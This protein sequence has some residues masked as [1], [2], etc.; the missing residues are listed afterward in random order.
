MSEATPE[1]QPKRKRRWLRYSLRSFLVL[2]TIACLALGYWV[3]RANRQRA[4]MKWVL[5]NGGLAWH[6]YRFDEEGAFIETSSPVPVYLEPLLDEHYL[7]PVTVVWCEVPSADG[8]AEIG[9]LANFDQLE[10]LRL[11]FM[12]TRDLTPLANL[13]ELR[14]LELE[15]TKVRDLTPLA[16]LKN[17][18]YLDLD[19]TAISNIEPLRGLSNLESLELGDTPVS[20]LS[21]LRELRNLKSLSIYG[22]RVT[23]LVPLEGLTSLGELRVEK[24]AFSQPQLN[25]LQQALP[26]CKIVAN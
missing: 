19:G 16:E 3:H 6:E 15:D 26:N 24:S 25:K 13:T 12:E 11:N 5:E 23:D 4:A 18:E 8:F 10:K 1:N 22:T 14:H 7:S 21:P 9:P 2:M 17:L 20:D